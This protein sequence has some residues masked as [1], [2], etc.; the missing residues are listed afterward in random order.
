M[1]TAT[2][3]EMI[4]L[5]DQYRWRAD[6]ELRLH[7]ATDRFRSLVRSYHVLSFEVGYPEEDQ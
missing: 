4:R 3:D 2:K 7:G 6:T 1:T 5:R